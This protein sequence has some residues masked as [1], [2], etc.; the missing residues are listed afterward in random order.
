MFSPYK[1]PLKTPQLTAIDRY[2]RMAVELYKHPV[3]ANALHTSSEVLK[4]LGASW[5]LNGRH[6]L[7]T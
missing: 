3:F 1:A 5:D 2:P 4:H 6:A 7:Y